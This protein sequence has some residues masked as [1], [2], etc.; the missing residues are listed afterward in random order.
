M[1]FERSLRNSPY[2]IRIKSQYSFSLFKRTIEP[3]PAIHTV[4]QHRSGLRHD[5]NWHTCKCKV[6]S[7]DGYWLSWYWT[8]ETRPTLCYPIVFCKNDIYD[9]S[10]QWVKRQL[11]PTKPGCSSPRSS[12]HS[13]WGAIDPGSPGYCWNTQC[14]TVQTHGLL[15]SGEQ[16]RLHFHRN[17]MTAPLG[18]WWCS[19]L[20]RW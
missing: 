9:G 20:P 12:M 18:T 19:Y 2:Q 7:K 10:I 16:L 8:V 4:G 11:S 15:G 1:V 17:R 14:M 3:I 5:N 6:A 13:P